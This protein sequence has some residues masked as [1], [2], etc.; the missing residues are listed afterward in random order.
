LNGFDVTDPYQPGVALTDPD[1]NSLTD[2]ITTTSAKPASVSGAGTNVTLITSQASSTLHAAVR[3]FFSNHAM[4]SDNMTARLVR[5]GF[6]G[7]ERLQHFADLSGQ[8]SGELPLV[9]TKFPFFISLST[10]RLSKTL[11]GFAARIE[12]HADHV[13]T[14]IS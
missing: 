8:V 14:E 10:Q 6:P 7:P 11:G 2:V 4:Q 1:F 3:G 13:L 5:L 12:T 9:E